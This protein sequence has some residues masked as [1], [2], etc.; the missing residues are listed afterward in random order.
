MDTALSLHLEEQVDGESKYRYIGK[1]HERM[2]GKMSSEDGTSL[3]NTGL[4]H[5]GDGTILLI[6][7]N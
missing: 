4:R 6:V 1:D 2:G 5:S 3:G 7:V